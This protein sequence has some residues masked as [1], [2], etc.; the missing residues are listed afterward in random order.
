MTT[1]KPRRRNRHATKKFSRFRLADA[2]APSLYSAQAE[3]LRQRKE[4]GMS[5]SPAAQRVAVITGAAKGIGWATVDAF[6][7]SGVTPI[8]PP[9][10]EGAVVHWQKVID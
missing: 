7:A 1:T 10:L 5:A 9:A 2:V 8:R 3:P 4:R 6:V